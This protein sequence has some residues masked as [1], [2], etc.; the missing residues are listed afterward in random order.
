MIAASLPLSLSLSLSPQL[1]LQINS[2][3]ESDVSMTALSS[4]FPSSQVGWIER[5]KG[6][7]EETNY[8]RIVGGGFFV[9]MI[10]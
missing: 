5:G 8:T 1:R 6:R 3:A 7:L 4:I 2:F 9:L 10:F